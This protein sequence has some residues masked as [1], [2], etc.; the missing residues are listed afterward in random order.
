MKI[1]KQSGFT[2]IELVMVI[3]ILGILAAF[4]L[5]RFASLT[6]EA[7]ASAVEGMSGSVRSAAAIA[8]SVGLAQ[9]VNAGNIDMEGQAVTLVN[10]YPAGTAAGIQAALQDTTGFTV[11]SAAGVTTFS[12]TGAAVAATCQVVYTQAAAA[13]AAPVITSDTTDCN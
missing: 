8:H 4:A 3:V 11:A 10:T 2:L 7:R 12:S 9:G 6:T 1:Q 5:P 13:G